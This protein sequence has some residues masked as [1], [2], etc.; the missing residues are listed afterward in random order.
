MSAVQRVLKS[1]E[2]QVPPE[3]ELRAFRGVV[4]SLMRDASRVTAQM[5][6]TARGT[7]LEEQAVLLDHYISYTLKFCEN[8][9]WNRE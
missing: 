9:D 1:V 6:L 8:N 3:E 4:R 5:M 7:R 2:K